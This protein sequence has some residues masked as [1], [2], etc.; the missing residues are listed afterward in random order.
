M[1]DVGLANGGFNNHTV[2][3]TQLRSGE[4][5]IIDLSG[6][7]YGY[8]EVLATTE[9]YTASRAAFQL[10]A[11]PRGSGREGEAM[12]RFTLETDSIAMAADTLKQEIS[13]AV[14]AQVKAFLQSK[15]LAG[16]SAVARF[17]S[18]G[19]KDFES[20]RAQLFDRTDSAI[21][22]V[23]NKYMSQ[24]MYRLC[25][26]DQLC[27]RVT[28]T[29][30]WGRVYQDLW[31][32]EEEWEPIRNQPEKLLKLWHDGLRRKNAQ[33]SIKVGASFPL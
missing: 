26:N 7:Q 33:K 10:P 24:G 17:L 30:D 16:A 13:S 25:L 27:V 23:I 31:L 20:Y 28:D 14:A 32:N 29:R 21:T 1:T 19:Q 12:L 5:F 18:L 15:S 4:S 8:R 9:D 6:A 11:Q 2:L 22:S 3:V